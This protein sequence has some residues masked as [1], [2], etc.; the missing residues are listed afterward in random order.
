M[1]KEKTACLYSSTKNGDRIVPK[2]ATQKWLLSNNPGLLEEILEFTKKEASLSLTDRIKMLEMG[3]REL[4]L[5]ETCKTQKVSSIQKSYCSN[6]CAILS[7]ETQEKTRKTCEQKYGS[8]FKCVKREFDFGEHH[9]QKNLKNLEDLKNKEFMHELIQS[10]WES[11]ARHF[12]LTDKSHSSS[13]NF[14]RRFGFEPNIVSGFSNQEKQ[15]FSFVQ[16][17]ETTAIGNTKKFISPYELDVVVEQKKLAIEY[18]GLYWHSFNRKETTEE[19][20]YHLQKTEMCEKLG[21]TL[22][23]FFEHEWLL[24]QNIIKSMIA[25]K[26]HAQDT[27]LNARDCTIVELDSKTYKSFCEKNH[28]QGYCQ[29]KVKLGLL[30]RKMN[31]IV[32][33]MSF[34]KPRFQLEKENA[35]EIV[36]FATILNTRV[37]GAFNKLLTHF[38]KSYDV[39]SIL[40]FGNRRWCNANDN[41]YSKCGFTLEHV[42]GPNYFYYLN[43]NNILSRHQCQ[44]SK[45]SK[46]LPLYSSELSESEL[47]FMNGYRRV[48]DCGSL[49]YVKEVQ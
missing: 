20:N 28:I 36:R 15:L 27:C 2:R 8:R 40:S 29:A 3:I 11:V 39:K 49:K 48:W 23:H 35:S 18:N 38:E 10:G 41:V 47:M 46:M 37:R 26:M 9:T 17:L 31:D 1:N 43:S 34:S 5:C 12:G 21:F 6:R 42:T 24:K 22:L 19:R 14:L 4:P 33:V 25:N 30:H 13:Y 44:K 32:S 7:K 45:L 16:S